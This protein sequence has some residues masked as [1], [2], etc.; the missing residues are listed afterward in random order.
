M[1]DFN[2]S[3]TQQILFAQY[4][5]YTGVVLK[6]FTNSG[7]SILFLRYCSYICY[8]LTINHMYFFFIYVLFV[9]N[10]WHSIFERYDFSWYKEEKSSPYYKHS[11]D[12]DSFYLFIYFNNET[13]IVNICVFSVVERKKKQYIIHVLPDFWGVTYI[14]FYFIGR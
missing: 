1:G 6:F 14:I 4:R 11:S 5:K 13:Y 2:W 9:S 7:V 3:I 10:C 8:F 12:L